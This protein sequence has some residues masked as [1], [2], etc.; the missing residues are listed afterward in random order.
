MCPEALNADNFFADLVLKNGFVYTVDKQRS[1]V[2]AIAVSEDKI[3]YIGSNKGVETFIGPETRVADLSGRMVLPGFVESH[4]HP[5][6]ASQVATVILN[7]LPSLEAYQQAIRNFVS[8]NQDKAAIYGNGWDNSLFPPLGPRKEDL[9][10]IISDRPASMMSEDCHAIWVNSK[11]LEICGVT[12]NTPAPQG[13][14]IEYDSETGEPSG[15]LREDAMDLIHNVLPPLTVEQIKAGMHTYMDIAAKEGITTVHDAMLIVPGH[16]GSLLGL[17]L[18]RENTV[19]LGQL[20][21]ENQLTLRVRASI[22]TSPELG[23]SQIPALLAECEKHKNPLFQIRSAKIFVDGVVEG[24][25]AFLLEPYV[26]KPDYSGEP[27]WDPEN[28]NK[29]FEALDREKLQIH[30]HAI[31]DAGISMALDAYECAVKANGRRDARHQVT[32]LQV[33]APDDIKRFADMDILG[34]PQ[35]MWYKKGAYFEELEVPYLGR[36]RAEKEYPMKSFIDAGV[37]MAS[38]SDFPV[39][40]P[41]PPML[42]IHGGVTRCEPGVDDPNEILGPEERVSVEEMIACY[43]INGAFANFMEKETGSLEVGKK[44]DIVVLN[45]NLFEIAPSEISKT[46]VLMTIFEGSEVY[47][48]MTIFE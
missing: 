39:N 25:T 45:K 13:G 23:V 47:R 21:E 27:I 31:G 20:S 8:A 38:A 26:H 32:H 30:V 46:K 3:I 4:A 12:K 35:P 36:E 42:G 40:V 29:M 16:T 24:S 34:V 1:Q 37:T 43:T 44:A 18:Y 11:A 22:H 28:L 15:T 6:M 10:A 41:C 33:L 9:D 14:M 7:N 5:T 2:E 48:D 17:G 19:A